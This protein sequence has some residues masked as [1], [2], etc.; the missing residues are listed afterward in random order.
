MKIRGHRIEPLEIEAALARL[1]GV[2]EA[3]AA[4]WTADG[5]ARLMAWIV[6]VDSKAAPAA[7][8]LRE[9]L[10]VTLPGYMVPELFVP[11][12]ALP[13]TPNG[14][15]DRRALP[16]PNFS[17]RARSARDPVAARTSVESV[18]AGIWADVL[19]AD[20]IGVDDD[21]FEL[22]GHSLHATRVIARIRKALQVDLPLRAFFEAPTVAGL[23]MLVEERR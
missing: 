4:P 3:V 15:I 5:D 20:A 8:A 16:A 17:R 11:L 21:F 10:L 18:I 23:A 9:A 2:K 13:L 1:P 7:T 22:G 12:D 19:G 6:P 14:K